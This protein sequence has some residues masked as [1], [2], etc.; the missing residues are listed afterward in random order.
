MTRFKVFALILLSLALAPIAHGQTTGRKYHPGQYIALLRDVSS[1]SVMSAS[2]KPGVRGIQKRYTW[3]QLEPTRGNYDF[4]EIQSD[5]YWARAYGMQLV[6]FIE[7]KTFIAERPTP[8]YLDN[9]TIRNK[10]GG[11]TAQRWSPF[12]VDRMKALVQALGARFDANPAFEGVAFQ[13]TS[14]S[15]DAAT[16]DAWGYTPEKYRDAYIQVLRSAGQSLPQSR[17][18]WYMNFLER[19]QAYLADIANAVAGYGVVMGGPDVLPDNQALVKL[20]YPLYDQ[21]QSRMP[22]FNQV[23]SQVYAAPHMTSGYS[24]K[25]W[26]MPELFR[27]ARDQLHVDYMFWVRVPKPSP[28]DSYC[29]LDALP[30]IA[31]NPTFN[32]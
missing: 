11:Y 19:G 14:H 12:V 30:V 8:A 26:T 28:Y 4:S 16:M 3:R 13:E 18:F 2:L 9:Y 6:V 1:Q 32:Q 23:E 22:L 5:L 10:Q 15:L 17:V 27:Y 25:Y 21:L 29:W 20:T 31:N 24:T 7:D